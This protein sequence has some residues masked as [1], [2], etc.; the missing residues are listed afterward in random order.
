M[1]EPESTE[2][3]ASLSARIRDLQ[4]ERWVRTMTLLVIGGPLLFVATLGYAIKSHVDAD[5]ATKL[6]RQGISCILADMD[7]HR[8]TNQFAHETLAAAHGIK[9]IQPDVIPLSREQADRLKQECDV[10][11]HTTLGVGSPAKG[12]QAKPEEN[13]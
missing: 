1:P 3:L 8:H 9:I 12:D 5:H 6:V 13:P 11:I 2:D 7:D 4:T 10:F